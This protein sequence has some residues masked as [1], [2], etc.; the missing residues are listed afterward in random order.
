[1]RMHN[2][3][4]GLYVLFLLIGLLL[5]GVGGTEYLKRYGR[6]GGDAASA[7]VQ[8]QPAARSPSAGFGS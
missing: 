6:V 3:K 5:G 7:A 8:A 4:A 1:M 2:G